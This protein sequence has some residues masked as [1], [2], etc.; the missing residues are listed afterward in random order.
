[1]ARIR[2]IKPDFFLH[3]ELAELSMTHRLLFIGLWTLADK[4]GRLDD[5]PRRI[6]AS[7]FPW[8]DC[9]V[10]CLLFDLAER[11]FIVRYEDSKK[12]RL[13]EIPGFLKHQRP[14]PKEAKYGYEPFNSTASNLIKRQEIK[15]PVE[16]RG[17]GKEI[18]DSGKEVLEL[19]EINKE[20]PNV[21][22]APVSVFEVFEHWKS[23]F[24]KPKAK[25]DKKR[26]ARI[27]QALKLGYSLEELKRAINGCALSRWHMGANKDGTIY[28][29]I[30]TI[31][32]DADQVDKFI[33]LTRPLEAPKIESAYDKFGNLR[34][35]SEARYAAN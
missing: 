4:E 25:L 22:V 28:D 33:A 10:D 2:T 20:K 5:R 14:H 21:A 15:L 17:E 31:F 12:A 26:E 3:E 6:K 29:G 9:D 32:R 1:M 11:G 8:D 24:G 7:I 34:D 27:S 19:K 35:P 13:I 16:S 23:K 30:Q 18:L